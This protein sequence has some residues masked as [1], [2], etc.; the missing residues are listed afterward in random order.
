MEICHGIGPY[1]AETGNE[2]VSTGFLLRSE[3]VAGWRGLEFRAYADLEKTKP[4]V[5]LRLE[6]LGQD[7]LLGIFAG[8]CVSLEIGQPPEG[9][10]FGFETAPGGGYRKLLRSLEDGSLYDGEQ[11]KIYAGVKMRSEG[12]GVLNW[13]GTAENI[14][15]ALPGMDGGNGAVTS[16]HMALEMIQNPATGEIYRKDK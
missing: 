10:H 16:A 9:M 1:A 3:M 2:F 8:E 11:E 7:V 4:L 12:L 15:K 5:P 6:T 14:Q 13:A